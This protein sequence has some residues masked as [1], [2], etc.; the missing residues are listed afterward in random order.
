MPW[1]Y[2]HQTL[3]SDFS[4]PWRII[5]MNCMVWTKIWI[6]SEV[7]LSNNTYPFTISGKFDLFRSV[8]AF[9][10]ETN[11]LF[12]L[13][14][15]PRNLVDWTLLFNIC[16]RALFKNHFTLRVINLFYFLTLYLNNLSVYLP[17]ICLGNSYCGL[18]ANQRKCNLKLNLETSLNNNKGKEL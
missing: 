11:L 16:M 4:Q 9:R 10:S 18:F 14:A 7:K 13:P 2:Q 6:G 1:H 12:L 3:L 15:R 8:Q 5:I 17:F